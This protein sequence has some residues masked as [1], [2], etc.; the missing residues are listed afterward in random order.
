MKVPVMMKPAR[1]NRKGAVTV[2]LRPDLWRALGFTPGAPLTAVM[3]R[4]VL[5][6]CPPEDAAMWE[7]L[8]AD[9]PASLVGLADPPAKK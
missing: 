4:D 3:E 8:L 6:L 5:I 9:F 2:S 7:L 1:G